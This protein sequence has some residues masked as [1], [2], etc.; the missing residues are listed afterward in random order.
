MPVPTSGRILL[1]VYY[2]DV[3]PGEVKGGNEKGKIDLSTTV[4]HQNP[5]VNKILLG[6][7]VVLFVGSHHSQLLGS[8]VDVSIHLWI[9]QLS[10]CLAIVSC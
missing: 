4:P 3:L 10:F 8:K 9:S 7:K 1:V 2:V 5:W 6:M